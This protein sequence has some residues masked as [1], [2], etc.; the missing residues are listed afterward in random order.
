MYIS[1]FSEDSMKEQQTKSKK[2]IVYYFLLAACVLILAAATVLT[3]YFV[4]NGDNVV[5][6][7]DDQNTPVMPPDDKDPDDGKDPDDKP[8]GGE[9]TKYVTPVN[10][11]YTLGYNEIYS[12]GTLGWHYRHYALDFAAEQGTQVCAMTAG[13][14]KEISLSKE[15]GN[16]ILV[17]HGEGL[18]SLYRFVEPEE[19]LKEGDKVDAGTQIGKV[20]ESYGIES[21]DGAH[22]HFEILKNGKNVDPTTYIDAVLEEK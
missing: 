8:T 16:Y 22:M 1:F 13:T 6:N 19:G 15:T 12:N 14:V 21:K 3:V 5:K 4:T 9:A 10:A 11:A 18:V 17:D 7:P 20:A 2:R